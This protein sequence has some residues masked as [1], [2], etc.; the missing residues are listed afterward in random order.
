M[1]WKYFNPYSIHIFRGM[2][3]KVYNVNKDC[4]T[5]LED[6]L[7]LLFPNNCQSS[8]DSSFLWKFKNHKGDKNMI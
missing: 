3:F 7:S 6:L 8:P 5:K 2:N 4:K 1:I